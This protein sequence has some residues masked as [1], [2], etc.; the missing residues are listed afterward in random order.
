MQEREAT[1]N[2]IAECRKA[3]GLR[4]SQVAAAFEVDQS[5]V[6]RWETTGRVPV[7]K[8]PALAEMLGVSVEYLMGWDA[9]DT[10]VGESR[11]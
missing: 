5:T 10:A 2:R 3:K 9:F 1:T 8:L 7:E 11:R 4:P 6:W